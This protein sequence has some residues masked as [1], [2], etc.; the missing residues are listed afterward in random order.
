[1]LRRLRHDP[2]LCNAKFWLQ[3]ILKKYSKK[4]ILIIVEKTL[5]VYRV[6]PKI[7][8]SPYS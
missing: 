6:L 7:S 8:G 5:L 1:M 4:N 3:L 2:R